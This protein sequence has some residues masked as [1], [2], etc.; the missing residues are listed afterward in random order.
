[1]YRGGRQRLQTHSVCT[2]GAE[3]KQ[4]AICLLNTPS[5]LFIAVVQGTYLLESQCPPSFLLCKGKSNRLFQW[6][7]YVKPLGQIAGATSACCSPT[8][9]WGA[10]GSVARENVNF[11]GG[12]HA[13]Q[14][15]CHLGGFV[16][17]WKFSGEAWLMALYR[18]TS[19][20][21]ESVWPFGGNAARHGCWS[22]MH[23]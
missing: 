11:E 22:F 12:V 13:A 15:A 16:L 2:G 21:L 6:M 18:C 20:C 5:G 7:R 8:F 1:M 4:K 19:T 14:V 10:V 9:C 17:K 23:T 3:L